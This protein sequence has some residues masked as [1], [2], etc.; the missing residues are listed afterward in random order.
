MIFLVKLICEILLICK[1][2][3]C[4]PYWCIA[5]FSLKISLER[6]QPLLHYPFHIVWLLYILSYFRYNVLNI[7]RL[8]RINLNSFFLWFGSSVQILSDDS[9]FKLKFNMLSQG[10]TVKVGDPKS[11]LPNV[12]PWVEG[13]PSPLW[14]MGV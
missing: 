8:C 12:S 3:L 11:S 10:T 9:N 6:G 5:P 7:H 13:L 2:E 14:P 4:I 1:S